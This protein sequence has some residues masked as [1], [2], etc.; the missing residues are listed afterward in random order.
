MRG[1]FISYSH[2]CGLIKKKVLNKLINYLENNRVLN[3]IL[4]VVYYALAVLPHEEVGVWIAKNIMKPLGRDMYNHR[5]FMIAAMGIGFYTLVVL[6]NVFKMDKNI[7][8][9]P[10]AYLF[11][12]IGLAVASWYFLFVF[13]VEAIHFLQYMLLAILMFPIFRRYGETL[14][15]CTIMGAVDEAYQYF[16][17]SPNRTNYYDFNDIILD[18]IGAAFG[19]ILIRSFRPV[20]RNAAKWYKSSILYCSVLFTVLIG[21]LYGLGA[22]RF[23]PDEAFPDAWLLVKKVP[24]GFWTELKP[25]IFHIVEPLEGMLIVVGLLVGFSFLKY[26]G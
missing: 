5:M 12:N 26:D 7:Q 10:L 2:E 17:L 25:V 24:E 22:L 18:L 1:F 19:L 11:V 16:I 14:F 4:I 23:Y 8:W 13:N 20:L 6:W 21:V 9:V 3:W 15:W